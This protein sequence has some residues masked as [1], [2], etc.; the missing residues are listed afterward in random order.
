MAAII[1]IGGSIWLAVP[2]FT[3]DHPGHDAAPEGAPV[4][5]ASFDTEKLQQLAQASCKCARAGGISEAKTRACWADYK[6]AINGLDIYRAA[7]ACAPISIEIDCIATDEGEKCVLVSYGYDA[8]CTGAEASLVENAYHAATQE[9]EARGETDAWK[10]GNDALQ[11]VLEK[12]RRGEPIA[13]VASI[14]G[15]QA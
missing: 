15:C 6:Q 1:A 4:P 8:I 7:T 11:D 9:A 5:A 14:G 12:L 10:A 3:P 2:P 13:P